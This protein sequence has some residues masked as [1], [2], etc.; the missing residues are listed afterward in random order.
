MPPAI[1]AV[2]KRLRIREIYD[3]KLLEYNEEN[4]LAVF[5]CSV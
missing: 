1:S 2:K 5:W 3:I 4:K